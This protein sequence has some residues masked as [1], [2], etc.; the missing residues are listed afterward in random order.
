LITDFW[1]PPG[2]IFGR[3]PGARRL[4]DR[5]HP[6]L[7]DAEVHAPNARFLAF[8]FQQRLAKRSGWPVMMERNRLFQQ[9][10]VQELASRA[11]STSDGHRP[12]LQSTN[13]APQAQDQGPRTKDSSKSLSHLTPLGTS[14]TVMDAPPQP[15]NDAPQAQDQGP[16]T[17]DSSK[18]LSHLTPLGTSGTVMD[19]P[20]QPTNDAPQAQDQGPRT[21]DSS[22]SLS[23]LA[24]LGTSGTARRSVPT[25]FSYSYAAL[26][27][28]R[29]AKARGWRTLLGQIDPGPE[30][31]R[32]VMAEHQR[33][34]HLASRWQPAP[35]AYWESWREEL[36][37]AD[38]IIVNS[39]WS[40][41]CL[42]KEGVPQDKLEVV[43]LVYGVGTDRRAVP[44]IAGRDRLPGG[45]TYRHRREVPMT[46]R[47]S[48]PTCVLFLGQINLRKGV[49]RLLDAM[50]M[51]K[52]EP[53]ELMLAGPSEIDPAA[54]ADLPNVRWRGPV[55]RSEVGRIYQEADLFI[56][57][58]LSDGYAL[59][60]LEALAH[61]LPVIASQHCGEAVTHGRN[62]WIL[63]DL[64]PETIAAAVRRAIEEPLDPAQVLPP[65]FSLDD[66]AAALLR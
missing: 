33:Y 39:E 41:Q 25:V 57:P 7:A 51:L 26:E 43:P 62:G 66:L 56:L 42:R 35:P 38:R 50:R 52:D 32:I 14:G 4:Q 54:W 20:P 40:W 31:E 58:T 5:F 61:G 22:K 59:T 17:M 6:D 37:L 36:K 29:D 46:A 55:P 45:P 11:P 60:Q 15:T 8:E 12:P 9:W 47:R 19:A 30:E 1:V 44:M 48:R 24:R 3:I 21:K 34:P 18:S 28:F 16:R 10:A 27:L 2:S 63:D 65:E 53:V 13:D 49:G 64:E 23:H